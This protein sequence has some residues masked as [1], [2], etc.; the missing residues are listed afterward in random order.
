MAL[1][2]SS[3]RLLSDYREAVIGSIG[4]TLQNDVATGTDRLGYDTY[5]KAITN[6]L[7]DQKT[8]PPLSIS[9]QA[10]WGAGKSSLMQQIR[11]KLD[12]RADRE[13]N[14]S[15]LQDSTG[16]L[17]HITLKVALE[18]LNRELKAPEPEVAESGK[19]WTVW[20]NA[21]KYHTSEQ[22]WAGLVDAIV[23]QISDRLKPFDKELFLFRLQLARIDDGAVRRKIY[24]RILT[25]WWNKVRNWFVLGMG[26]IAAFFGLHHATENLLPPFWKTLIATSPALAT[27]VLA[28]YL[29]LS[30]ES[31]SEK[32]QSEPASFSLAP[33]L[34]VPDYDHTLGSIHHIHKDLLRVLSLAPRSGKAS[35]PSPIVIF[36]DDL[37]RCSP[38]KVASVVEGVN[39]F[40]A[41]D[42]YH[43]MFV[44]GMDPQMIAAALQ[45]AHSKVLEQ[46]PSFECTVPLGW[47]FMDKFIQL[48]FTIP[49]S[50]TDQL[51]SYV[52]WLAASDNVV[53]EPAVGESEEERRPAADGSFYT[54]GVQQS[55]ADRSYTDEQRARSN[56]ALAEARLKES[57]DVGIIIREAV[58]STSGNP[59][60]IK[61]LTNLARLYLGLRN[62]R[63]RDTPTWQPPSLGQYA[64]WITLTLRWPDMMRWLQWGADECNWTNELASPN[65]QERRLQVLQDEARNADGLDSWKQAV[66]K[67]LNVPCAKATDWVS[68]TKLFEFFRDESD[69][70]VNE[71]LSSAVAKGFW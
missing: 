60:E 29:Y 10:P 8:P 27:A 18:Y 15:R 52:D 69:L 54:N 62:T 67:K 44:I 3:E 28:I 4:T 64:R 19:L 39:M 11:E 26:A 57:Q 2:V 41:S 22:V 58:T 53:D 30:F 13:K 25:I 5:A 33:Y 70:D 24:D 71:R 7:R 21:W 47:R 61:R 14:K 55:S 1:N 12:P 66:A 48:P 42:D 43:C 34:K 45:E 20:F 63:K 9:I 56:S 32:T 17:R 16:S 46:L 37:D 36:I 50:S 35:S 6:F 38:S 65:L 51:R 68:D 31:S 49:P 59:R 23:S 40:L